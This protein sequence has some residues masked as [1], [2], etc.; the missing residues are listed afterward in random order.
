[1]VDEWSGIF[2]DMADTGYQGFSMGAITHPDGRENHLLLNQVNWYAI[3]QY[4]HDPYAEPSMIKL[5]WAREEFGADAA[6]VVV[7]VIDRVTEAAR[8]MYEF[9]CLWT[10][11]HS[12][13]PT[14]EYLDSHLCGPYRD[15]DRMTKMMGYPLPLDMYP[16]ERACEIRKNPKTHMLFNQ[17]PITPKLKAEAM[18]Q[19]DGATR[20][21]EEA[22]ALWKSLE[23]KI[24]E[25]KYKKV[26]A[27]LEGNRDDTV[28]FSHMMDLYMDWK[29]GVLTEAK[30]DAVLHASKGLKGIV[31]PAP[32]DENPEMPLMWGGEG[33]GAESL[34][35]FAEKLREDLRNPWVE[36]FFRE[37]PSGVAAKPG[38]TPTRKKGK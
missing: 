4:I 27:G 12:R 25:G 23:G 11:N 5:E 7:N 24:E 36:L 21:M 18:A 28:I 10:G 26:L 6:P 14:L 9:D 2:R 15:I 1:M 8:G 34:K 30:I 16:P 13:F 38:K 29:L 32:L 37:N 22:I 35:T 3:K 20:Y 17:E 33:V 31:V 19:K